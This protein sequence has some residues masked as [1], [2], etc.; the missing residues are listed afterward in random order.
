MG[1][2]RLLK[3]THPL[4]YKPLWKIQIRHWLGFW[5]EPNIT[6]AH[7]ATF[8]MESEARRHFEIL[9]GK[10]KIITEIIEECEKI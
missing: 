7:N 8:H 2:I 4:V 3:I 10:T 1:R 6:Y 9:S 5:Y